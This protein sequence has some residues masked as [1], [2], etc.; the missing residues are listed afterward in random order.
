MKK[1]LFI[2]ALIGLGWMLASCQPDTGCRQET[3]VTLA[4]KFKVFTP[5]S[6][7]NPVQGT[8]IDSITIQGVGSDSI[9]YK[10]RKSVAEVALPLRQD[11]GRTTFC[12]T[13]H[14]Q[15]AQFTILHDNTRKYINMAC[16]CIIFH[17]ILGY[18]YDSTSFIRHIEPIN[19]AVE[20]YKNIN[21]ELT[22]RDF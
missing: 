19:D 9:L 20:N 6:L 12:L 11:T 2:I 10:N 17:T 8:S 5:D 22:I 7:G 4:A 21:C 15:Q 13:Y 14:N 1:N 16:G 18:E 3:N